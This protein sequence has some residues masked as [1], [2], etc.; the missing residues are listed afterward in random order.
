MVGVSAVDR[1][2]RVLPEAARGAQV[3]F[4]APGNQMVSAS[5]GSP[6]YR[7][8]RGTSF[9]AP[10]VAAMLSGLLPRPDVDGAARALASL[11][12]MANKGDGIEAEVGLGVVGREFRID[13]AELR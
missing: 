9:A 7:P 1:R 8:V 5:P 2:G 11:A 13:P 3:K 4:A 12:K 6:P 10:I